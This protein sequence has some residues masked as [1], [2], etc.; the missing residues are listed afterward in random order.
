MIE[1]YTRKKS[2]STIN[3]KVKL[4]IYLLAIFIRITTEEN[5]FSRQS[6]DAT[7]RSTKQ[8][9]RTRSY[10]LGDLMTRRFT[11]HFMFDNGNSNSI[12]YHWRIW[13]E[14]IGNARFST[15]HMY[16]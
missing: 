10:D 12:V 9:R 16:T 8:R 14:I 3:F 1:N 13:H 5:V 6:S 15:I 11:S 7:Q 2:A 4:L